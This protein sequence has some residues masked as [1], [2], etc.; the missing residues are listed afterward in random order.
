MSVPAAVA[1]DNLGA[2]YMTAAPSR[3]VDGDDYDN[4]DN[5]DEQDGVVLKRLVTGE[6][7]TLASGLAAPHGLAI[8]ADGHILVVEQKLGRVLRLRVPSGPIV[9]AQAFTNQS[10][11]A[12]TGSVEPG[13]R[14]QVFREGSYGSALG[15]ATADA[16]TGA[17]TRSVVLI[18]NAVNNFVFIATAAGGTGLT[19]API[20]RAIVH[21]DVLP[22]T[23]ILVPLSDVHTNGLL[24]VTARGEDDGSGVAG[25][26]VAVDSQ[27]SG[28]ESNAD[29]AQPLVANFGLNTIALEEGPH[30]LTAT[31]R[32]RA[33]NTSF[34]A[35]TFT[36]DR[37]APETQI[38]SGPGATT[39]ETSVT[40]S[41][42]GTD[43]ISGPNSLTFSWRL[44]DAP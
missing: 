14:V 17:F 6:L 4:G 31:T 12:I 36:V 20:S 41:V 44:D 40:F 30:T 15:S 16:T 5:D 28:D 39:A 33:A 19:S 24:A 23:A 42:A 34:A 2:V 18:S 25:L 9:N 3:G 43:A 8:E 13:S 32:D 10:P 37:T 1:V 7:V 27:P 29:P 26:S 35:Q 11:A 38:I 22:T 21:D